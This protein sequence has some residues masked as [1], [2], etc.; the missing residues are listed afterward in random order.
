M[1]FDCGKTWE[2]R[3]NFLTKWHLWFAWHPVRVGSH[4][5]R[6]LEMVEREGKLSGMMDATWSW[7][8][9]ALD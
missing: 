2:E 8:Y 9:R 5:C 1:K 6:W 7:E 3:H 4:D